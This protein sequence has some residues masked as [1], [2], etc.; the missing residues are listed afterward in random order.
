MPLDQGEDLV[1]ILGKPDPELPEGLDNRRLVQ[2]LKQR[3]A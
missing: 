2:G 1:V 3:V